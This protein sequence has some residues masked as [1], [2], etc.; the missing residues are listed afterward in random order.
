[1]VFALYDMNTGVVL[2]D[3]RSGERGRFRYA[4]A[5]KHITM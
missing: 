5:C 3:Q 2:H 1:M 4:E